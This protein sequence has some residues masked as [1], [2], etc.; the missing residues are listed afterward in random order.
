MDDDGNETMSRPKKIKEAEEVLEEI[1][2]EVAVSEETNE[3]DT[4]SLFLHEGQEIECVVQDIAFGGYGVCR[5][6]NFVIFVPFVIEKEEIRIRIEKIKKRYGIG[7]VCEVLKASPFRVNPPCRYFGICGGCQYQHITYEHQLE[8]KQ[9]QVQDLINRIGGIIS[10]VVQPIIPCPRA[11]GYRNR[12]MVRVQWCRN[13][14]RFIIGYLKRDSRKVIE[15]EQ[16]LLAEE[17]INQQLK[18]LRANPPKKS[19]YKV[20]LR[21]VPKEWE[22]P[23]DSFFQN[24]FY[25]LDSLSKT[26]RNRLL[27][28]G[29]RYLIDV[30]CG[31][32]FFALTLADLVD[33]YVGIEIDVRAV[34]AAR[35]NASCRNATNGEFIEGSAEDKLPGLISVFNPTVTSVILDPPR[36]GCAPSVIELLKKVRPYQILYVSCHPATLARDLK[37]LCKD[38]F[39]RVES[40]IPLDMFPQTQHIECIAD[41]RAI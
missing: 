30:Y 11:Y 15:I 9:K 10:E 25:M 34:K 22:V 38:G 32:G 27:N 36:R 31:V 20:V 3:I 19:G 8:I 16:C 18:E 13:E 24:N 6:K 37:G 29:T 21:I 39:Y 7:S 14:G 35:I 4:G 5:Y 28:A 40:V 23:T 26:V 12:I 17:Q 33:K 1:A 2:H 41:L